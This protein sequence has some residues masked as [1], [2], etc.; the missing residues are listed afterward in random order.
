MRGA[1]RP[2]QCSVCG[3]R[4]VAWSYPRPTKFCYDCMPGGLFVPPPCRRCGRTEGY[5]SGGLCDQCHRSAPQPVSA[6]RDCH[7]WGV[8]GLNA[9]LCEACK[10]WRAKYAE[11]ICRACGVSAPINDDHGCRLCWHQFLA[12]GGRKSGADL[13]EAN[14]FGQQLFIANLRHVSAGQRRGTRRRRPEQPAT[15]PAPAFTPVA[16]RQLVLFPT[17]R[18]SRTVEPTVSRPRPTRQWRAS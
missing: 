1:R 6:C 8:G 14:R 9:W 3:L 17:N 11:G 10:A 7:A 2:Q 18:N 13:L 4:P 16:H 12:A 5:Y 15:R